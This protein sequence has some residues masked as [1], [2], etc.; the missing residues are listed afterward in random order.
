MK[1]TELVERSKMYLKLLINGIHPVTGEQIPT[2]SALLG[3]RVKK[4]F[5]FISGILDEYIELTGKVEKLEKEKEANTVIVMKKQPFAISHEQCQDIKLSKEPISMYSLVRN[6]NSVINTESMEKMTSTVINKWLLNRGFITASK[7]PTT[8]NKTVFSPS[9]LAAKIGIK[10]ESVI[11]KATGEIN[12]QIKFSESAQ[13][14]IIENIE[15]ISGC[16]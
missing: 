9:E 1:K 15:E 6:I 13:L 3:D 10:T 16:V 4:C 5:S 2:D 8:V 7:V 11:N 14:F 12:P